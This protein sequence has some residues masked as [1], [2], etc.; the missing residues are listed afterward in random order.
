MQT[1]AA[2]GL[3]MMHH[4][5]EC[6]PRFTRAKYS[7]IFPIIIQALQKQAT[8]EELNAHGVYVT[9]ST[10]SVKIQLE[11]NPLVNAFGRSYH[12]LKSI[13]NWTVEW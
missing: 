3:D 11:S 9:R 8:P 1:K 10:S 5:H 4:I 2:N 12:R 6:G 13:L 7:L